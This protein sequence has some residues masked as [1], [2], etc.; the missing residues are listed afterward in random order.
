MTHIG[1]YCNQCVIIVLCLSSWSDN[2]HFLLSSFNPYLS[3]PLT[4]LFNHSSFSQCCLPFVLPFPQ[5]HHCIANTRRA[6]SLPSHSHSSQ[7]TYPRYYKCVDSVAGWS[8]ALLFQEILYPSQ[9]SVPVKDKLEFLGRSLANNLLS[10]HSDSSLFICNCSGESGP[11]YLSL[12]REDL[13]FQGTHCNLSRS[14]GTQLI[15]H[16]NRIAYR[17]SSVEVRR[18]WSD[19]LSGAESLGCEWP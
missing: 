18:G 15:L 3:D 6:E 2:P 12:S 9:V 11:E 5:H 8:S 7:V 17:A 16:G 1:F 13:Q 10:S 4:L 14:P 19:P